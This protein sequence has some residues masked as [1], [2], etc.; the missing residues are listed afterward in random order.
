MRFLRQ[1]LPDI[2]AKRTDVLSPRMIR[3]VSDLAGD[4]RK[5]D[6]RIETSP[7]RSRRWRKV[8]TI[9]EG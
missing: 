7:M 6:E 8:M 9:V 5:L 1:Q 2:L 3:I 4:W